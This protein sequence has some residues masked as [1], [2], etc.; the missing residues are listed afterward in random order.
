MG[1]ERG[2]GRPVEQQVRAGAGGC[3]RRPAGNGEVDI[4]YLRP[5][6]REG[7]PIVFLPGGPGL[8]SALPYRALRRRAV[9]RGLDVIMMEHRGVGASRRD[10]TGADL[11]IEAVTGEAA[12]DDLAAVLDATG[13]ERA[14]VYG[15]S[16]GTYLAQLFAVRHPGRVAGMVLD[17]PMLSAV[18]DVATVRAFRR[19]LLWKGPGRAAALFRELLDAEQVPVP[20]ASHVVQVVYEFAG[21][22]VLE[23]LLAARLAGRALR[24]WRR[25]AELGAG[26]IEGPGTRFVME[27]DLVA[28]ITHGE[29][30]YGEAPDG[31][32]LDPQELFS[33]HAADRPP[34][35]GERVDLPAALPHFAW[36]TAVVS[37][38]RDLRTPRPIA[39][40]IVEL[41][42][43]AVLVPLPDLGHSAMD[44]HQLAALNVAHVLA[45]GGLGRLPDLTPRIAAL[46]RR[47]ASGKLGPVIRAALALE[48]ALPG[49]R[50]GS[51]SSR[52]RGDRHRRGG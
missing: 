37:G 44:T 5:R 49:G 12:A 21:P 45:A 48:L 29:L 16:Y 1:D 10:I 17:S 20:E 30:G 18:D 51:P 11:A 14:V 35:T 24:T 2:R 42:P 43:G 41:V 28:G 47:G 9:K 8:A 40:R 36:P 38:E 3:V 22:E 23:R 46:P 34:F 13:V 19:D 52:G 6:P 33:H 39:E 7:T 27:P 4:A 50:Q 31:L 15:S 25:V 32:P 26:E